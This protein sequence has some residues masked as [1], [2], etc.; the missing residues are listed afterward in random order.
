M[1][2]M[3][4]GCCAVAQKVGGNPELIRHGETGLLF[5]TGDVAGLSATLQLLIENEPLRRRLAAA[6][7]QQIS[8]RFSLRAAAERMGEIYARL[9]ERRGCSARLE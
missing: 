6:A 4:C 3:A 7:L 1:E 8:T 9:I 2:A 5:E